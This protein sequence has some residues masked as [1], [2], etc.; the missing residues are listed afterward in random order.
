MLWAEMRMLL[1][2]APRIKMSR[3]VSSFLYGFLSLGVSFEKGFGGG[4]GHTC[5]CA[6]GRLPL[7]NI[8]P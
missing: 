5:G 8:N 6:F 7:A 2:A 4:L 3:W 1:L